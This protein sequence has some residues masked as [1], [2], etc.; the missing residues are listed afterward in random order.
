MIPANKPGITPARNILPTDTS[1]ADAYTT[2]T[3]DGGINIPNVPAFAIT[4][5]ANSFE[6][7]TCLIPAITIVPI[8]TTVAGDDPDKAAN[9]MQAKTPA[10][11][12]PPGKCP[13]TA[14]EKRII[15][16]ATPTVDMNDDARIKNGIANSV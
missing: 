14:I 13:T 9:S 16:L 11:A 8:A 2:I 5:A 7:P 1:V 12:S 10:I 3:I 4:P 15:L 6:Y